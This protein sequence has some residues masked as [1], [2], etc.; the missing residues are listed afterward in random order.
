MAIYTCF[1]G[2]YRNFPEDSYIIGVARHSPQDIEDWVNLAPS[3]KLLQQYKN[4]E[5]DE[6]IFK[7]KY[8]N[9]L[10]I[11]NKKEYIDYLRDLEKKY[12]NIILCCYE[13]KEDFCHRHILAEW[14]DLDIQEL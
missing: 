4:K 8:L 5:I 13:K 3:V 14:L 1:F 7:I 11:L 12:K 2:N 6:F 9:E 10:Y